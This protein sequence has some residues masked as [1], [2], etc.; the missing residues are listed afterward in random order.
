LR[1][2]DVP[3]AALVH[4]GDSLEYDVRAAGRLGI[5]TVWLSDDACDGHG[6]TLQ[7]ATLEGLAPLIL[8]RFR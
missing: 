2:L 7:V 8:E 6:A 3:P 5:Q 4:V 1:A